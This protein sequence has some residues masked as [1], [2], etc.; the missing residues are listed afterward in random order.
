MMTPEQVLSLGS[1]VDG[2]IVL[3]GVDLRDYQNAFGVATSD[4]LGVV[5][6]VTFRRCFWPR[7]NDPTS[8]FGEGSSGLIVEGPP[9]PRNVVFPEDTV[10]VGSTR[11][12]CFSVVAPACAC[13][14]EDR[15]KPGKE[16]KFSRCPACCIEIGSEWARLIAE[17]I[18]GEVT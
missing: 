2:R 17:T 18:P 16:E 5:Q 4:G 14:S 15:L 13:R 12:D 11:G 6:N 8:L 10:F 7:L 1:E 9:T 3:V